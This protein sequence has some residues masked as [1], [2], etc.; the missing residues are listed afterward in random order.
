MIL[1]GL[2][3]EKRIGKDIIIEP[4][5]K[6]CINPNSYNLKLHNELITYT[7]MPL[8]MKKDNPYTK[9]I[10]PEEGLL[11]EPGRLYLGRTKEFTETKNLV[12][13]L[14]GRSSVGRL[15]LCIHVTAGFGDVGFSG[16]WTLEIYTIHPLRIY[17]DV[18]ICQI[19]YHTIEG[20]HAE[21]SSGKYQR[22]T[23]IQTSQLYR[24]FLK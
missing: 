6:N 8:D 14:E 2:E 5:D 21:Y 10:I 4:Y 17:P 3:I 1:S 12:P 13:M 9:L 16:Y 22:N 15:G 18:E 19:Y 23:G 11:L 7:E 20:E 24:D